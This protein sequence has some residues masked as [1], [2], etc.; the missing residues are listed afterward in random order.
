M[1]HRRLTLGV[2]VA[3]LSGAPL[4]ITH[5]DTPRCAAPVANLASA[6]GQVDISEGGGESWR[7]STSHQIFCPDDRIRV[8]ANSRAALVLSNHTVLRL[9]AHSTMNFTAPKEEGSLWVELVRGVGYFISRVPRRLNVSTPYVNAG[10]EGTEFLVKSTDQDGTVTVYEGHVTASNSQGNLLLTGG[11][12]AVAGTAAA[13]DLRVLVKPREGL[14]W[15]LHY[16]AVVQFNAADFE[17]QEPLAR[18]FAQV[19]EGDLSGALAALEGVGADSNDSRFFAYRASLHL[20]VGRV[21]EADADLTRALTLAPGNG[22]ALALQAIVALTQNEKDRGLDLATRAVD[23]V[24]TASGPRLALSYAWQARFELERARAEAGKAVELDPRNAL[25]WAR[26]AELQLMFGERDAALAAA[27]EAARLSPRLARSQSVLG[28]AQLNDMQLGTARRSFENAAGLDPSD[29]LPQLGLGLIEVR[30]GNVAIGRR[31][32]ELA[33]GLDPDNALVRSYLGKAYYTENRDGRAAAQFDTAKQLDP[34]DPTPWF[35]DAILKQSENRPA[36]ALQDLQTSIALNDNRAVYR[37]RLLLDSDAAARNASLAR[38]YGDLGFQQLA[39]VE[40]WKSLAVDPG[41][42]S[43]HRFL[44]DSY[45]ALPRHEAAR[46]SEVLQAQLWQ[47]GTARPVNPSAAETSLFVLE[48]SGPTRS[49]YNE[50]TPLFA[51]DRA[52][53]QATLSGGNNATWSDEAV[54]FGNYRNLSASLGQLH[55]TTDGYRDNNDFDQNIYN[56][57]LQYDLSAATSAQIEWRRRDIEGGDVAQRF[58]ETNFDPF[59]RQNF[60]QE[61]ARVGFRHGFT[62]RRTLLGSVIYNRKE[63][64]DISFPTD[65][66]ALTEG[67]NAELQGMMQLASSDLTVGAG[68]AEQRERTLLTLDFFGLPFPL[69]DSNGDRSDNNLYFY[70]TFTPQKEI[71]LTLGLSY[72]KVEIDTLDQTTGLPSPSRERQQFNP[73]FGLL[74]TPTQQTTVRLAA[75]RTLRRLTHANQ[76]IEPSQIAGFNQFFDDIIGTKAKRYGLGLDHQFSSTVFAGIELSTRDSSEQRLFSTFGPSGSLTAITDINHNEDM[77]RAY[78]YQ[79]LNPSWNIA[80]EYFYGHLTNEIIPGTNDSS[81]PAKL[82][83]HYLPVSLNYHQVSGFFG[84]TT[85]NLVSQRAGFATGAGLTT[86]KGQF[87]TLDLTLGYRLASHKTIAS[88]TVQNIF[89]TQFNFHDTSV[90]TETPTPLLGRFR[91]EMS[92]FASLAFWF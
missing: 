82:T 57:F 55:Y 5:A 86:D 62:P 40:A 87:T 21:Q 18:S 26:L 68:H 32:L 65:F 60:D 91:P 23:A 14:Q 13:P 25:A 67:Y 69:E 50:F 6:E 38:I 52:G 59:L 61:S 16:P 42:Y 72:D 27:E 39:L 76:S 85:L 74:W 77:H 10:V 49:A 64:H 22:D 9:G 54:L 33:A 34:A 63:R 90:S 81:N 46:V 28:Y 89:D 7:S 48:S 88:L 56:A 31:H 58:G 53:V 1:G 45:T 71:H 92:L 66:T 8:G 79:V 30:E 15:A 24:P 43:A 20:G 37:S 19:K 35:Y 36:E 47:P 51:Q 2:A 3:L 12:S 70:D 4:S 29:P 11:Q 73:K 17:A 78:L 80:T 41:N 75:F 83:S 84:K 44:A